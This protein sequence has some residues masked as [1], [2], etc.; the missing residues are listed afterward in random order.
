MKAVMR[1]NEILLAAR[2][3]PGGAAGRLQQ[4]LP[5][6]K[7]SFCKSQIHKSPEIG[8]RINGSGKYFKK[9]RCSAYYVN[10]GGSLP[11]TYM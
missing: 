1:T 5:Q 7:S 4:T 8:R 9:D 2:R 6:A 11:N 10:I 3:G